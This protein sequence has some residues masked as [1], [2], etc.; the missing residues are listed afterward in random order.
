MNLAL[1]AGS[2]LR[3]RAAGHTSVVTVWPTL[4]VFSRHED[5]LRVWGG[6]KRLEARALCPAQRLRAGGWVDAPRLHSFHGLGWLWRVSGPT[7]LHGGWALVSWG[8]QGGG[9]ALATCA[10]PLGPPSYP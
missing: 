3:P 7:V 2:P 5:S 6:V 1:G 10:V 8:L 9:S 4:T